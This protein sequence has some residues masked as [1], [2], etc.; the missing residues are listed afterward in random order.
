MVEKQ[1]LSNAMHV[2][3][4]LPK[5]GFSQ[6]FISDIKGVCERFRSLKE[7]YVL[8]KKSGDE[9]SLFFCFLFDEGGQNAAGGAAIEMLAENILGL[10]KD[11]MAIDVVSLNGKERLTDSVRSVTSPFF[12]RDVT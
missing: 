7:G 6:P 4:A 11:N 1:V 8:L 5:E 9:V 10:F 12:R 2:E 3:L